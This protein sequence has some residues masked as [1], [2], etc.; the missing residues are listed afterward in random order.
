[1]H[2]DLNVFRLAHAMA[3]HAGQRQA[4]VSQ[5]IANADTPGYLAR[6][7]PSFK[8]Q[9]SAP[10]PP[11][12][13]PVVDDMPIGPNGNSVS[14]ELEILK[15]VEAKRQHDRAIAIYKASLDVLRSSLGR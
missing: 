1:M 13:R 11:S 10:S 15:S 4:V 6:D 12:L 3:V 8:E 9:F 5:N 2:A 7:L 14:L